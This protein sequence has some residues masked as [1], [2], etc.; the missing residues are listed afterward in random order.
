M[1]SVEHHPARRSLGNLKWTRWTVSVLATAAACTSTEVVSSHPAAA[2]GI[3]AERVTAAV[4]YRQTQSIY[5]RVNVLGESYD[6]AGYSL[7]GRLALHLA[8]V[9]PTRIRSLALIST[10]A[11][12]ADADERA[13]RLAADLALAARLEGLPLEQFLADWLDQPLFEGL[14][15]RGRSWLA[16]EIDRRR[17]GDGAALGESLR[18]FGQAS[19]P[20]LWEELDR[21]SQPTL[22][23]TGEADAKYSELARLMAQRLP[24][25]QRCAIAGC[26][27]SVPQERP[28]ALAGALAAFWRDQSAP[29]PSAS[30]D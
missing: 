25:A 1:T 18:H 2:S 14:R 20:S 11:G 8:L 13:R 10:T 23:V 9:D 12:I 19:L 3:T 30:S 4:L 15:R 24:R 28:A 29:A 7:G 17:R 16:A 26:G 22:L 6:L 21:I 27:H 5:G